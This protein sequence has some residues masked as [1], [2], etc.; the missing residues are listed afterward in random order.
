MKLKEII[1]PAFRF[2]SERLSRLTSSVPDKRRSVGNLPFPTSSGT[3]P[4]GATGD[5]QIEM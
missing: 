2:E 5:L 1:T 3:T 4:A